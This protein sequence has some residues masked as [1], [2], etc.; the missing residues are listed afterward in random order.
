MFIVRAHYDYQYEEDVKSFE[1]KVD[2]ETYCTACAIEAGRIQNE[3]IRSTDPE[4]LRLT[5]RFDSKISPS[6]ASGVIY[7]V[8]YVVGGSESDLELAKLVI[9]DSK[10]KEGYLPVSAEEQDFSDELS[11]RLMAGNCLIKGT[12]HHDAF[13]EE[14]DRT[15]QF[16]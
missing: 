3:W 16:N 11:L 5:S 10:K 7:S 12:R 8:T 13:Y 9:S 14:A 1:N 2:A 6:C 15:I 4:R